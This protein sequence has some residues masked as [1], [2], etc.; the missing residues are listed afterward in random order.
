VHTINLTSSENAPL[1]TTLIFI[2]PKTNIV[3]INTITTHLDRTLFHMAHSESHFFKLWT[4]I[5]QYTALKKSTFIENAHAAELTLLEN[6][7]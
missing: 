1:E 2:Y 5:N 7:L 6:T 3:W 4:R